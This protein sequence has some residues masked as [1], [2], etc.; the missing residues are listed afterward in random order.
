MFR[1]ADDILW[2]HHHAV[3]QWCHFRAYIGHAVN[4]HKTIA[5]FSIKAIQ[6]PGAVIF[7]AS[8]K[9]PDTIGKQGRG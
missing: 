1:R 3:L 2:F 8:G 4:F 9:D 5:A 6:T 7:K